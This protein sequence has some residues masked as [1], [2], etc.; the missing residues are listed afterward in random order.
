MLKP[1]RSSGEVFFLGDELDEKRGATVVI[2]P[3]YRDLSNGL[4]LDLVSTKRDNV[5][6]ALAEH[7]AGKR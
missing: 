2:C 5:T 3:A 4:Y 7:G 6:D 1:P